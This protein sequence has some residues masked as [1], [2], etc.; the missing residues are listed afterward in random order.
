MANIR[1][2]TGGC[3]LH[4]YLLALLW[5]LPFAR[6]AQATT[7]DVML[8]YDN[9][10]STWVATKG[11]MDAFS[12][13]VVTRINQAMQNSGIDA[14]FRL[15]H[16]MPVD[17][18]T[19]SGPDSPLGPDLDAL[20]W[21]AGVFA[22]VHNARDT[23]GADLVAMLVDHGSAYGFVG[24]GW[25][26]SNWSGSPSYAY[27]V[28]AIRSVEIGHTVTHE[29]GHNFGADHSKYQ[30]DD[31][32]P[33]WDLDGQYSAGWY[34]MGND[35][36]NYHTIMAYDN[37]GHGT[38]YTETS[39][40]STPL[41][42]YQGT[43]AGDAN[44]GDNARLINLTKDTIAGYRAAVVDP[45]PVDPDPL[46]DLIVSSLMSGTSAT[47]GGELDITATV[48]NQGDASAGPSRLGYYLSADATIT[49]SDTPID[50]WGCDVGSLDAG[51][52]PHTCS[53][54]IM[55]P[56]E[57]EPGTYYLGAYADEN[58][59][60]TE[61]DETNNGAA[62]S[63]TLTITDSSEQLPDLVVTSVTSPSTGTAGGD[64]DVTS[65]LSNQGDAS[66]ASSRLGYYLSTDDTITLADQAIGT[67]GCDIPGLAV[68]EAYDNCTVA[69]TLP[70]DIA[71]GT[72]YLGAY[73]DRNEEVTE[74]DETNNGLA[75]ANTIT[76]SNSVD[77]DPV[78]PD[79]VSVTEGILAGLFRAYFL[80]APDSN[81]WSFYIELLDSSANPAQT[82]R[83]DVS[84]GFFIENG[85]AQNIYGGMTDEQFVRAIYANVL[86]GTDAQQP[87]DDEINFWVNQI[88]SG[89][90]R[91]G[92]VYDFLHGALTI[93]F[94]QP[95]PA[96]YTPEQWA[97]GK[98]RQDTLKNSNRVAIAFSEL[99]VA[100]N[101]TSTIWQTWDFDPAFQA[102]QKII[103]GV[104]YD[105]S[106]A[107]NAVAFL[108][109]IASTSA[110]PMAS[111]NLA[112]NEEIYG[113]A[114]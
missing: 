9:T 61:S 114:R 92:M 49:L 63:H 62:T 35:G 89:I 2:K 16:S 39:L 28:N 79:P 67:W 106:A 1:T 56:W 64:I 5:L 13:D 70:S 108:Q 48:S 97:S 12:Q 43:T 58:E 25:M 72:Y 17:Y 42:T 90:S 77:P 83:E 7:I 113:D 86:N 81:G 50:G 94:S 57:I 87:T 107:D 100:T 10:A 85:Y 22:A 55:L 8:V 21:G 75:A 26:L 69:I 36:V 37:D 84:N 34:F 52:S 45:D 82:L 110:D 33:N 47:V 99:G 76:I 3:R 109:D 60:V 78:D 53:G 102:S 18:N 27:T 23:Y 98:L 65:T 40:F 29:M 20:T 14:N 44:N 66:A 80:R 96:G 95:P 19:T 41:K 30:T 104:T 32:G 71:S 105:N 38:H 6:A 101:V 88:R 111:I 103:R 74:S 15:V 59:A 91:G 68:G 11:G 112:T 54:A 4:L 24:V 73:A 31:P 93:D 46:P 51:A